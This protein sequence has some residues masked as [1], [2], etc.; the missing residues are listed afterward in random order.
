MQRCY[1]YLPTPLSEHKVMCTAHFTRLR[2]VYPSYLPKEVSSTISDW[3]L[4]GRFNVSGNGKLDVIYC[5]Y[6]SLW[7]SDSATWWFGVKHND[8][9]IVRLLGTTENHFTF[10]T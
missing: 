8:E 1:K 7:L 2:Y 6:I 3:K 5:L 4:C 9:V 10:E